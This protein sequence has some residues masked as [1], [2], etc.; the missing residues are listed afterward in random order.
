MTTEIS[1]IKQEIN[2]H[3]ADKDVV[4]SLL[5]TTFSSLKEP[6]MKEA[7]LAAMMRGFKFED[8]LNKN[9]YAISYGSGYNLVT[10]I[11]YAR[12]IAAMS[13]TY[14]GKSEPSYVD[15]ADGHILTCSVTVK[16]VVNG[17][18]CDFAAKVYFKEYTTGKSQWG[19]KPRTMIAKVAEM[20]ALRMAFP[21]ELSEAFVEEEMQKDSKPSEAEKVDMNIK[22][23]EEKL[24]DAESLADLGKAW[25]DIPAE[26]KKQLKNMKD[27]LKAGFTS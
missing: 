2:R 10:S 8:F 19:T 9:V 3:L 11:A 15:D 4:R 26:A 16:K 21:E 20:H 18:I 17:A 22:L 25:A 23:Y 5:A 12:K 13:G 14:A 1:A 7:L 6:V 27:E 24:I